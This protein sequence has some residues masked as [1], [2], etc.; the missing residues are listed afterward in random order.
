VLTSILKNWA[1]ACENDHGENDYRLR[2]KSKL[3]FSRKMATKRCVGNVSARTLLSIHD[4]SPC[5]CVFN[6]Q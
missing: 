4:L 5:T 2:K 6:F 3:R 1:V